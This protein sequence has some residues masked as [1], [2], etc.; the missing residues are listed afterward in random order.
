MDRRIQTME[1]LLMT[2][3]K[4]EYTVL[5][6]ECERLN[7]LRKYLETETYPDNKM[8]RMMVGDGRRN[9]KGGDSDAPMV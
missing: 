8:L 4:D 6:A 1:D 3:K 2:I 7:M 9:L 5:V